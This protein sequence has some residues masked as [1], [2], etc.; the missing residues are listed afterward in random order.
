MLDS[1]HTPHICPPLATP[2]SIM[3]LYIL[4]MQNGN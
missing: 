4:S 2:T 3:H 1:Q